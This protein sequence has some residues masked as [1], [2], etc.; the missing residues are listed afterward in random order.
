MTN[1]KILTLISLLLFLFLLVG[2]KVVNQPPLITSAPVETATVGV[3]YTYN[4]VAT[5]PNAGDVLTYSLI[6]EPPG[7][8]INEDSGKITWKADDITT[9]GVGDYDVVVVVTDDGGLSVTQPFTITVD[10][11]VVELVGIE[12][13]PEEMILNFPE[14]LITKTFVVTA[15]YNDGTTK[16]V[17]PNCVYGIDDTSI[18]IVTAGEVTALKVGTATI[19]ISYTEGDIT[20]GATLNVIVEGTMTIRWLEDAVRFYPD[21]SVWYQAQNEHIPS[22]D[23]GDNPS[24][25]PAT[26]ILTGG[27]YYFADIQE[28]YNIEGP[29]ED[30][31]GSIVISKEGQL[32]GYATYISPS[33]SKLPIKE[34]FEGDVEIIIYGE[35][36]IP[37]PTDCDGT[38][39]GNYTQWAYAYAES[40][41]EVA[42]LALETNYLGAVLAPEQGPGWWFVQ[43]TY[44]TAHGEVPEQ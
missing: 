30:L 19:S 39:V 25:F 2:C 4:V 24:E 6:D 32:S 41:D 42:M 43:Y 26:L 20:K 38:M 28:Y 37:I 44:Y 27:E 3:D 36:A 22:P 31:E 5:D 16:D 21:G 23:Y 40:D 35:K 1:K 15:D 34:Y 11:F 17:T 33:K 13:A 9:A 14:L 29:F 12:V 18:A 8:L 10:E 7:M